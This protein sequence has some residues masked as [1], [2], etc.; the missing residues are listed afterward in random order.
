MSGEEVSGEIVPY[1]EVVD[2][3]IVPDHDDIRW[4][5]WQEPRRNT[6]VFKMEVDQTWYQRVDRADWEQLNALLAGISGLV[7]RTSTRGPRTATAEERSREGS[8]PKES[9]ANG[10]N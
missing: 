7:R 8:G 2:A 6:T 1:D 9:P 3:E 5:Q 10:G 4:V